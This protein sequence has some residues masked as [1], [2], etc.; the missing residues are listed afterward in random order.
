MSNENKRKLGRKG[1]FAVMAAIVISTIMVSATLLSFFGEIETTMNVE[2]AVM[3][4]GHNWDVPVTHEFDAIGGCTYCFEHTI[5]NQGCQGIWLDWCNFGEPDLEGIDISFTQES[6]CYLE[7]LIID[8]LDGI[9]D[10]SFEVYVDDVLVYTYTDEEP[11]N[12]PENWAYHDIDLTSFEIPSCGAHTIKI[13]ATGPMWTYFQ[14]YGQLGINHVALYCNGELSD[15]V[16]IG[17]PSSEDG[18]AMAGWGPIEPATSGG[19]WGGIDHCR[20]VWV[21]EDESWATVEL[22]GCCCHTVEEMQLPFY[23]GPGCEIDFN[24]CY[25]LD[26]LIAPGQYVVSS[27]LIPVIP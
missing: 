25:S 24:I 16:D 8:A 14:T 27:Q 9:A 15:D 23:L 22:Q 12:D 5:I 10:D 26:M 13:V 17:D 11:I 6:P 2:Q 4:D 19:N 1:I 3:I 7:S 18:H 20:A 21:Y